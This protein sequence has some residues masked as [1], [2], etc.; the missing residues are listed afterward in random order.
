MQNVICKNTF[1]AIVE[2]P[3]V[4]QRAKSAPIAVDSEYRSSF[5]SFVTISTPSC[6]SV[7]TV[8]SAPT[9]PAAT[10]RLTKYAKQKDAID[11]KEFT[12]VMIRN[13]P[14]RYTQEELIE[15]I[16]EITPLF[17]FVYLPPSKRCEGNVG[18]AFVNFS[19]PESAKLF[20]QV[21]NGFT[22]P[23]QPT[24][25]KV[26]EVVYAVLQGLKENIKFYK[27]SKVRKSIYINR[28]L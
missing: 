5:E 4:L 7:S 27:K 26:A 24:S 22:F 17:N 19:T 6:A 8:D 2:E 12:T 13:I 23:R 3:V 16:S 11:Q 10:G 28:N 9:P 18:Y 1:L 20:M 25:S 21:F 14:C 15:D